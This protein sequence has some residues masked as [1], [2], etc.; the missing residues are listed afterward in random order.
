[1]LARFRRLERLPPGP[2]LVAFSGG[3]D[4]LALAAILARLRPWLARPVVAVHVDHG[5]RPGSVTE[6]E[7]AAVLAERLGLRFRLERIAPVELSHHR[8]VGVE[9]AARRERYRLLAGAARDLDA[10]LVCVA[11]QLED[12]AE[13]LLLHLL[14]GSGLSG[15]AGMSEVTDLAVPWWED[16]R[17]PTTAVRIWRPLLEEPRAEL[18]RYLDAH[19][20]EPLNDESNADERFLRNVVRRRVLPC[21]EE[22]APGAAAA[23]A[24]FA[25][26]AAADDLALESATAEA[27]DGAVAA[28]G[29]LPMDALKMRTVA[30]QRRM[31]RRW[32]TETAPGVEL[33]A[34]A[35]ESA[36]RLA[37]TGAGGRTI[38]I[39]Q[40]ISVRSTSGRLTVETTIPAATTPA[41][42][43]VIR[44]CID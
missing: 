36:R 30:I 22:V 32:L 33:T 21:L 2:L 6:A 7:R 18:V 35:I 31:L 40:G 3:P 43:V 5:L 37:V 16:D 8:G 42:G 19:A 20:L 23:L 1:M 17:M 28:D 15:A 27:L 24:R 39:G 11:H 12:Q 44:G 29:S 34:E 14:R 9:E 38:E 4:S 10:A 25:W 26:L 13:T 41:R